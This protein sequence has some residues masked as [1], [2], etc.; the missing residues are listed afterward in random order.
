MRFFIFSD[1]G[2]I[3]VV[4]RANTVASI[5]RSFGGSF[6]GSQAASSLN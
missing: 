2:I 3:E 5:Q 6:S 4:P 1:F